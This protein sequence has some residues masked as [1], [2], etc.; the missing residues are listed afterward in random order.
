M[1]EK[2]WSEKQCGSCGKPKAYR[3]APHGDTSLCWLGYSDCVAA[4]AIAERDTL[5]ARL[6]EVTERAERAEG[7]VVELDGQATANALLLHDCER[8]NERLERR[9]DESDRRIAELEAKL[10]A[11]EER[12][13]RSTD[14]YQ[15]RFNRL[16]R[17]VNEEV[18]PLSVEVANRYFCIVANGSA[19]PHESADWRETMHGLTVQRDQAQR[20]RDERTRE[21]D[22]ARRAKA[23]ADLAAEQAELARDREKARAERLAAERDEARAEKD[24]AVEAFAICRE[25]RNAAE[26]ERDGVQDRL[27]GSMADHLAALN[28][29]AAHGPDEYTRE[30]SRQAAEALRKRL[31]PAL[32]TES[33]G[34]TGE[35]ADRG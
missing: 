21:R 3:H 22:E 16:R 2:Q 7:R 35:E 12:A 18:K 32:A 19:A 4:V 30:R 31:V 11:A 14:W 25:Q 15:Q 9:E 26:D 27:Y 23:I 5:R 6:A 34:G 28:M 8:D 24:I 33:D 10:R 13:E 17:W 29:L 20:E 1:S